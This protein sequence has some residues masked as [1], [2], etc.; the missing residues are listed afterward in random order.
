M[1]WRGY[2]VSKVGLGNQILRGPG[3]AVCLSAVAGDRGSKE[4]WT[5]YTVSEGGSPWGP[6]VKRSWK[7][8]SVFQ[9]CPQRPLVKV[10]WMGLQGFEGSP[11]TLVIVHLNKQVG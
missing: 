11:S 10:A 8:A 4:V 6:V 2:N 7:G 3:Q 9:R 5:D 1:A